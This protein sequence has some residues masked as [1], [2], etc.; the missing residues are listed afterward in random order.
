M[1]QKDAAS[2]QQKAELKPSDKNQTA[3]AAAQERKTDAG[4]TST[5]GRQRARAQRLSSKKQPA[6]PGGRPAEG[7]STKEL[8]QTQ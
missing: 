8:E 4:K 5:A 1:Q 6:V 7:S 2:K 3:P